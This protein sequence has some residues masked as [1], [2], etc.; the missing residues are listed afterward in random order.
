[1]ASKKLYQITIEHVDMPLAGEKHDDHTYN[2]VI[3]QDLKYI[4]LV[5]CFQ[6][7]TQPSSSPLQ[8]LPIT[9]APDRRVHRLN[10]VQPLSGCFSR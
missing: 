7:P 8:R 10:T 6:W 3:S 5:I 9:G 1:M 2:L 4:A